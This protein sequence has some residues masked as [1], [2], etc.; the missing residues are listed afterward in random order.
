MNSKIFSIC[1]IV[2]FY[3][4]FSVI[5]LKYENIDIILAKLVY[6]GKS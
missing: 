1:E 4:Q 5:N 6:G 3:G 2:L